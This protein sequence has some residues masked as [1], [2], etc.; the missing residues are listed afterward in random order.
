MRKINTK[1]VFQLGRIFK[2]INIKNVA[3]S[4]A[5][6][7]NN[8]LEEDKKEDSDTNIKEVGMNII[9]SVIENCPDAESE[10]YVF[11][12]NISGFTVKEI[13]NMDI[14][15]FFALLKEIAQNNDLKKVFRSALNLI[16]K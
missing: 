4:M 3:I 11:I 15:D 12:S 13:E 10:I 9:F 5:G 14:E 8:A 16:K 7:I 1:D 6:D 2:K